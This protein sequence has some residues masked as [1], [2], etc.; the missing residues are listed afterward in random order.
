[1]KNEYRIPFDLNSYLNKNITD[2]EITDFK[3]ND[4]EMK[5]V[6]NFISM[7]EAIIYVHII[8]AMNVFTLTFSVEGNCLLSDAHNHEEIEYELDDSVDILIDRDNSENSD[9]LPDEDGIYDLRGCILALLFDAI[10]KNF[11]L[12]PLERYEKDNYI[13]MSQEEYEATHKKQGNN[14]FSALDDLEIEE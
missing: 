2:F 1:M 10:P 4:D 8:N 3:F 12:V 9:L 5:Y 11:S 7:H 6:P 14:A 13:V